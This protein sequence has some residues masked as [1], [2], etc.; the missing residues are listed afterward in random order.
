MK[1]AAR[2][3]LIFF[4]SFDL[5][6][7]GL[8]LGLNSHPHL[9][10]FVDI[11]K[12][13][14]LPTWYSSL[15]FTIVS[16]LAVFCYFME[17]RSGFLNPWG[18]LIV[19]GI[20]L[21]MSLDETGQ[22]HET[23]IHWFFTTESGN[24]LAIFFNAQKGAVSLLWVVVF[25]PFL[26]TVLGG[27]IYFYIN[28]LS[29]RGVL[30]LGALGAVVLLAAAASMEYYEAKLLISENIFKDSFLDTYKI[31]SA[32]EETLENFASTLLVWVHY[33]YAFRF[34]GMLN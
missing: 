3:V 14:N 20:T 6:I 4:I 13:G 15:K 19:F 16:G 21:A 17:R 7:L 25:S 28:R 1:P 30:L 18:W 2:S 32:I 33:A 26:I 10:A 24:R 5:F 31:F 8:H 23:L 27:L 9:G 34:K 29:G 11:H 12:E 22:L